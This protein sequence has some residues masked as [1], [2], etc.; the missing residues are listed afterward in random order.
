VAGGVASLQSPHVVQVTP[1]S[2]KLCHSL[3]EVDC[4]HSMWNET[5]NHLMYFL[6]PKILYVV[7]TRSLPGI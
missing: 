5:V 3:N 7:L 4:F 1:S 2:V 6:R